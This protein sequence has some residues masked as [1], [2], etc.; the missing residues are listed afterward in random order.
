MGGTQGHSSAPP[1]VSTRDPGR[2]RALWELHRAEHPL[3]EE[4]EEWEVALASSAWYVSGKG[5]EEAG[6]G[7]RSRMEAVEP[8]RSRHTAVRGLCSEKW[9]SSGR[10]QGICSPRTE[11]SIPFLPFP[12][13]VH[14][15]LNFLI[16]EV[17]IMTP[18][19]PDDGED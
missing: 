11:V 6:P 13:R 9:T 12:R 2:H 7:S 10:G 5:R 1:V 16:C 4:G 8:E 14:L 15:S 19:T 18:A 3:W 17:Q